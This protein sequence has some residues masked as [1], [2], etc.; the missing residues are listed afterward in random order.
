M[1]PTFRYLESGDNLLIDIDDN[2]DFQEMFSDLSGSFRVIM[3]A[4]PTGK[5]G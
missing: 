4:I 2:R 5:S 3:A 1:N